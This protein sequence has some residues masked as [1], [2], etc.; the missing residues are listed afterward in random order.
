[1]LNK[2]INVMINIF[3]FISI[4]LW[5]ISFTII[6]KQLGFYNWEQSQIAFVII[7][8]CVWGLWICYINSFF[9]RSIT[10]FYIFKQNIKMW[11][12]RHN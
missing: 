10:H 5:S 4:V 2:F 7:F 6:G 11:L 1:M 3:I 9:K 8:I 12:D